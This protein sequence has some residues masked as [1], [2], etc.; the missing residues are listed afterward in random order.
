MVRC[1]FEKRHLNKER[2]NKNKEISAGALAAVRNGFTKDGGKG[3]GSVSVNIG[4]LQR[5]W[6]H[7]GSTY[8]VAIQVS[9]SP[10]ILRSYQAPT[11]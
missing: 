7:D 10:R 1:T 8:G 2:W 6:N 11:A 4:G 5:R 9:M 3:C